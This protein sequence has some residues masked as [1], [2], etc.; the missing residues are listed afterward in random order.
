[1]FA[2][3]KQ[4]VASRVEVVQTADLLPTLLRVAETTLDRYAVGDVLALAQGLLDSEVVQVRMLATVMLG[5]I[6]DQALEAKTML[7]EVATAD[8]DAEVHKAV[9][10]A[11]EQ[12]CTRVGYA[13][14]Q[15]DIAD[16]LA[17]PSPIVRRAV[18]EGLR[19]WTDRPYFD[20]WPEEAVDF[21][22]WVVDDPDHAVAQAALTAL[23]EVFESYPAL[24][25]A[26]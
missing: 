11:F 16:W 13:Y 9:G 22:T 25:P 12:Y 17:D 10:V 21:L 18:I 1:M 2:L 5:L 19:V 14:V 24:R 26:F 7:R 6:A 15:S 4:T 23:N 20:L 3:Q 8:K